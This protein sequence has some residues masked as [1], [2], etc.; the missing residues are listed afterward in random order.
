MTIDDFLTSANP[1]SK[2]IETD[3]EEHSGIALRMT[4]TKNLVKHVLEQEIG[5]HQF[6]LP[7]LLAQYR[8]AVSTYNYADKGKL[9][10]L[11]RQLS[12]YALLKG[13]SYDEQLIQAFGENRE[14]LTY[15]KITQSALIADINATNLE[16]IGKMLMD[17]KFSNKTMLLEKTDDN[18]GTIRSL[19]RLTRDDLVIVR[20]LVEK[21]KNPAL[22][23]E[24]LKNVLKSTAHVE[25]DKKSKKV[26]DGSLDLIKQDV[27]QTLVNSSDYAAVLR[28]IDEGL[29]EAGSVRWLIHTIESDTFLTDLAQRS[30][31]VDEIEY[32]FKFIVDQKIFDEIAKDDGKSFPKLS[33]SDTREVV[34]LAQRFRGVL[35]NYPVVHQVGDLRGGRSNKFVVG[36]PF[37]EDTLYI[38]WSGTDSHSN[39][40][41]IFD[42]LSRDT[43]MSFPDLLRS[44]GWLE[45]SRAGRQVKVIL[46]GRSGDFGSYSARVLEK[47]RSN[48]LDTLRD[49]LETEEITLTIK[50]SD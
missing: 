2:R 15:S 11:L 1:N 25:G 41:T 48:L 19:Y 23:I 4:S 46:C 14:P 38:A 6:S 12:D 47:F 40:A 44:G 20:L 8:D 9:V 3:N 43:G 35:K 32:F 24:L 22:K 49:E 50:I 37:D 42:S 18:D 28:L 34:H 17:D 29:L 33:D 21:T 36:I 31:G 16:V 39:H 26:E 27:A 5:T 30:T 45:L 10:E 13:G 7:D